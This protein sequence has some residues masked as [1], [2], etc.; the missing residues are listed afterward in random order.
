MKFEA[1]EIL[2]QIDELVD[3]ESL[4]IAYSGGLD[5]TVLLHA[6]AALRDRGSLLKPL[7]ALHVNHGLNPAAANW[8]EF[9]VQTCEGLGVSLQS[10]LVKIARRPGQ[11]VEEEAR[12]ARYR[13]FNENLGQ[14]DCLLL[15]HHQDD[16]IE[17]LLLR[18][19][20]GSGPGGLAGIPRWRPLGE[21]QLLRPL[22]A[23]SRESLSV[24]AAQHGLDWIEDE[25]NTNT[26]F[27]RNFWRQEILPLIGKRFP[28]FRESWR[29][30]IT[31]YGEADQMLRELASADLVALKTDDPAVLEAVALLELDEARQR[32]VLRYWMKTLGFDPPGWQMMRR[33][34]C[35]I[36]SSR[37]PGARLDC[38]AGSIRLFGDKLVLFGTESEIAPVLNEKIWPLDGIRNQNLELEGNGEL[39]IDWSMNA[40]SAF[41]RHRIVDG[42]SEFKVR[43]R[44]EGDRCRLAGRPTKALRKI[45]QDSALPIWLRERQPLVF[46][47]DELVCVPGIGVCD[48][49][50]A[51]V[52][53]P[54]LEINWRAP[55]LL[56]R[57]G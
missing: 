5:S 49:F 4:V 38:I 13:V 31:L 24:Y 43:Y 11:S 14:G 8:E 26:N 56:F 9:C 39:R 7:R 29:K 54:G 30:S 18:L 6:V 53:E 25:S 52:D 36:L 12:E 34:T 47:N 16:E 42:V 55:D 19:T 57:A 45:L 27:D 20:R 1:T 15:A 2:S 10:V 22:L 40:D 44:H 32:N 23:F 3:C 41:S 51:G 37:K 50:V 17:N 35:E 46:A 48:G 28:G 21:A 33:L